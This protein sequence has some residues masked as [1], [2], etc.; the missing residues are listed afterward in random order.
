MPSS[1]ILFTP[2]FL[3]TLPPR[4][5]PNGPAVGC[6]SAGGGAE[7]VTAGF[8]QVSDPGPQRPA[9]CL[10]RSPKTAA[11]AAAG[12]CYTSLCLMPFSPVPPQEC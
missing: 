4:Q 9:G 5:G 8:G 7:P 3:F 1:K 6:V 12:N 10:H 11:S 2:F